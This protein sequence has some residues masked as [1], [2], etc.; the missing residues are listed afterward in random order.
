LLDRWRPDLR[1]A[2]LHHQQIQ[3]QAGIA[4]IVFLFPGLGHTDLGRVPNLAFD[5]QLFQQF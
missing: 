3:Q 4:S 1:K 5:A 2:I